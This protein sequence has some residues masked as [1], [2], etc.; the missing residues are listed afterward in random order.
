MIV[1]EATLAD[2]ESM[3]RV[4]AQ[5]FAAAYGRPRDLEQTI[6]VWRG[7]LADDA[8]RQ[9]MAL[10]DDEPVG[11]LSVSGDELK[12]LY[13][14]PSH[15]GSGAG[16]ALIER[17]HELLAQTCAEATLIVLASN[18][19]ARRFYERNGWRLDEVFTEPH[20]GGEPT[21]VARYRRRF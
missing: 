17:A 2:A 6:T 1:R 12:V 16:Q 4:H 14:L 8:L 11:V 13:V 9:W 15:W 19:R 3:A 10:E 21:D 20:F 7:V 18:P 5:S